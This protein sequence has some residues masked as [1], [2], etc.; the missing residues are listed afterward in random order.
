M[1]THHVQHV[2]AGKIDVY[3]HTK[4]V[5]H[6]CKKINDEYHYF[7]TISDELALH[8]AQHVAKTIKQQTTQRLAGVPISVKDCLCVKGVESTAG[9]RILKGYKPL[10]HATAVE[11][12]INE[13]AI[14]IGKTSQ[15]EFGFGSF[16]VNV[17]EGFDIPSNPF[18]TTR[19]TGGSSGGSCGLT[20][21]ASFVHASL[22][23]STGGSIVCPAAFC[24][25]YGLCP[26]YGLVSRY[27]LIDYASS[28]DKI[29]SVGSCIEDVALLLDVIAGY[30]E[31]DST[32]INLAS[33]ENHPTNHSGKK[34]TN[35]NYTSYL[36]KDVKR[37]KLGVVKEAFGEGVDRAIVDNVW[38]VIKQLESL[39]MSYEEIS[40]PLAATYGLSTYYLLA[41]AEASTNLAKLC[42]LRYGNHEPLHG[43]FN[44][45]FTKVR[46]SHFGTEAKR[47]I[48]IGTFVR[49]AGYRDAYYLKAAQVRTKI[50]EEYKKAFKTFDALITPTMPVVAPKFSEIS[51]MTPLQNYMMDILVVSPNLAGIPHLNVPTGFK[52]KM[53]IGTLLMADHLQEGTLLQVGSAIT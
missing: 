17:G 10:F 15:D 18:D 26:T 3:E 8:Q 42:G 31:K 37:L 6:D 52:G 43:D 33:L 39:G 28:L 40:M 20:Q 4:K 25:V 38:K 45:Y 36:H 30:D 9:S 21:K 11:K 46:T 5:L 22:V 12:C 47:R 19:T 2:H 53:P 7:N 29:G 48:M 50:I 27:G 16:N 13:G 49:M 44:E 32:S 51:S 24:G 23:E 14:I 41:M 35:T 1:I 34:Q